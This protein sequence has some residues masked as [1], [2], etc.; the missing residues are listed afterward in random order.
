MNVRLTA[1]RPFCSWWM[2]VLLWAFS[3]LAFGQDVQPVPAL[4]ARVIQQ[5]QVLDSEQHIGL[6]R[7]LAALEQETGAQMVVLI[8]NSAAPEDIAAYAQRVAEQWKIGRRDV[9]DGVL[10]VVA[11]Q[12]RRIR[13]EVAK[14]LEGAI[15]DLAAKRII[16][17]SIAPAFKAGDYAGGLQAGVTRLSERIRAERLGVPQHSSPADTSSASGPDEGPDWSAWLVFALVGFP[18]LARVVTGIFGRKLGALLSG[19]ISGGIV[20]WLTSVMAVSIGAGIVGFVMA[21]V[22]G[23][24][25]S[26][27]RASRTGSGPV[28]WGPSGGFGSSWGGGGSGGDGG[29]FS[30]GGGGDFGGGG[31]SGD[32]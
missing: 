16:S 32:W 29:G 28:I 11:V 14:A 8:I 21:L 2:G 24:A 15:P 1:V 6:E 9:G 27:R 25:G 30:S 3:F 12:D 19:G 17:E 22:A 26:L 10:L 23:A 5:A 18:I 7:Q 31:A 4:S 13:V 20:W